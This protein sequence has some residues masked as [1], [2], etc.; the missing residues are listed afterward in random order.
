MSPDNWIAIAAILVV[1]ATGFYTF[2]Y[3]LDRRVLAVEGRCVSHQAVIDSIATLSTR[4][5]NLS[6]HDEVFW[7]V[8]SPHLEQIIHSPK[9]VDRDALV[10]KLV[11]GSI[12]RDE[13]PLLI[14]LLNEALAKPEWTYEKKLAGAWLLGRSY[15]LLNEP[16]YNRRRP[17]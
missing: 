16:E 2:I 3:R 9:S 6:A 13:L 7:R 12:G 14:E 5:D 1:V 17:E 11:S 4:L 15:Q 8:I 10:S